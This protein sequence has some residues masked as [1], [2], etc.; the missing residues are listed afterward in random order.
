MC[1][2]PQSHAIQARAR[3]TQDQLPSRGW[4]APPLEGPALLMLPRLLPALVGL[5]GRERAC[6][7][8]QEGHPRVK[9][10]LQA[11]DFHISCIQ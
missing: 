7:T 8:A 2:A 1:R 10:L 6:C 3:A 5:K 4:L 11:T 9:S